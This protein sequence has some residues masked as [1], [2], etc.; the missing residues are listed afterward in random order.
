MAPTAEN[1]MI[2][3]LPKDE[4]YLCEI[5]AEGYISAEK[6]FKADAGKTI[7]VALVSAGEAWDGTTKSE[8]RQEKGVYQIANGA[9]LAW[10]ADK[11]SEEPNISGDSIEIIKTRKHSKTSY[12]KAKE[13]VDSKSKQFRN[14]VSTLDET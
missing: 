14:W 9:E 10:F 13:K 4:E 8:P 2:Y 12:K 11:V 1:S 7:T 6:H 5:S 3:S